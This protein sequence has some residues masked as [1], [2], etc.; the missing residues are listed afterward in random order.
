VNTSLC[1]TTYNKPRQ[2]EQVL[3]SVRN[4]RVLPDEILICDDGSTDETR[5]MLERISANYPV[6]IRHLWHPDTGWRLAASRN[7]GIREA[8]GEYIIFID[9]D[10][11]PHRRFLEDHLSL[12]RPN[13]MV[14]G[15]R[16]H[17]REEWSDSFKP[18]FH[19]VAYGVLTKRI[20][21]RSVAFRNP[22][23]RPYEFG[24][25]EHTTLSLARTAI[26][27]N[28]A[29]WKKDA[30]RI[31]GFNEEIQ[32]WALEDIEMVARMLA[33]GVRG[34]KVRRKAVIYHLD[35]GNPVYDSRIS[36]EMVESVFLAAKVKCEHDRHSS[37]PGHDF[38]NQSL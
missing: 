6:R 2:L 20:H 1:I 19:Q 35:H 21:K 15:D 28:M 4:M 3:A 33:S 10:C 17:V 11:L 12:A 24:L 27:C 9:G 29:F 31:N 23:E 14:L 36:L 13:M 25:E 5:K 26:G 22:F 16:A 37:G 18:G 34:R 7:N 8:Q 38:G 32:G 30:V